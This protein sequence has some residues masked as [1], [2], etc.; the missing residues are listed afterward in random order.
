MRKGPTPKQF[1]KRGHDK[2]VVGTH[3]RNCAECTRLWL[4]SRYR[5][6]V[7]SRPMNE[8]EYWDHT[9]KFMGLGHDVGHPRW[10]LYYHEL[11]YAH[12]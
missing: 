7:M 2:L 12:E 4:K 10:L 11:G 6:K 1:C 8:Q 3:G 9:L 5:T